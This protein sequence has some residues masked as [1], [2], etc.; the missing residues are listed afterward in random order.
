MFDWAQHGRIRT[1]RYRSYF[2]AQPDSN[3]K[4][5]YCGRVIRFCYAMHDQHEKTFVIGSCDFHRY[6][7]TKQYVALKA[8]QTL[9]EATHCAEPQE[10]S[11]SVFNR[12]TAEPREDGSKQFERRKAKCYPQTSM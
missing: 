11:G 3:P 6:K 12:R 2:E 9:L 7:G 8:A 5:A 1:H 4:C 10:N